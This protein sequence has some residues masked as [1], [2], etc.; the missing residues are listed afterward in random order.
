MDD[1]D[2][3]HR[4]QSSQQHTQG[5]V[6]DDTTPGATPEQ[7]SQLRVPAYAE[8][9]VEGI[10]ANDE[11]SAF[12]EDTDDMDSHKSTS[13]DYIEPSVPP[14]RTSRSP[15]PQRF[16]TT[17]LLG[18]Y[19]QKD[20]AAHIG[21]TRGFVALIE[22]GRRHPSLT[23]Q[24]RV[25]EL[26]VKIGRIDTEEQWCSAAR[27][28][29][30]AHDLP[31]KDHSK[32]PAIYEQVL[33]DDEMDVTVWSQRIKKIRSTL[34]MS[35]TL[36]AHHIGASSQAV[37]HWE[38]QV[39]PPPTVIRKT[40]MNVAKENNISWRSSH[41]QN[42]FN[43][44]TK[45][46]FNYCTQQK[47]QL[48]VLTGR[49]WH[50]FEMWAKGNRIDIDLV[51][52]TDEEM[53]NLLITILGVIAVGD[54][55]EEKKHAE[56]VRDATQHE[57][58]LADMDR[59]RRIG[60]LETIIAKAKSDPANALKYKRQ[61][62]KL[63]DVNMEEDVERD[64]KEDFDAVEAIENEG[65]ATSTNDLTE[66]EEAEQDALLDVKAQTRHLVE[67]HPL[68]SSKS[69]QPEASPSTQDGSFD[70]FL[71]EFSLHEDSDEEGEE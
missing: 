3:H 19:T 17:R 35:V 4:Q 62:K 25:A 56:E 58:H 61:I 16:R 66:E 29:G 55:V 20:L 14:I 13:A 6:L 51:V 57:Q 59:Q 15:W 30:G 44:I 48:E 36:F 31:E 40:L 27:L 5:H 38:N 68:V 28:S 8:A 21:L 54:S 32:Q 60:R 67:E 11:T 50:F 45:Y 63:M 22:Q 64:P 33:I 23:T 18:K 39:L 34:G 42:V 65:T 47:D 9:K 7:S 41:L 70:D 43:L 2:H 24:L 10:K 26:A 69:P 71:S 46:A 37:K 52:I 49:P 12:T 1:H 53:R